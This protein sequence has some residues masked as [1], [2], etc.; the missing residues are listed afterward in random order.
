MEVI[1][2]ES[3]AFSKLLK[4]LE[5]LTKEIHSQNSAQKAKPNQSQELPK[6]KLALGDEWLDNEDVCKVL[7]VTKRTLQN[8]RDNF[9]L[10]YSQI[11]K[12]VLYKS[13]DVQ[14]VLEKHYIILDT[15]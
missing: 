1:T 8:Y 14:R 9:I 7:R 13:S 10:P 4:N 11:G 3:Q 12:K 5:N 2:I 6:G 15:P